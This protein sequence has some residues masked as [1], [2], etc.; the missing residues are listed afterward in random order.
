MKPLYTAYTALTSGLFLTGFPIFWLYT[1]LTGRHKR[2]LKERLGFVP[3]I[4]SSGSRHRPRIWIHAASLG[5]VRVASPIISSL[6]RQVPACS[7][8]LSATTDHGRDLAYNTFS[9][10]PVLYAPIDTIFSVK[11]ALYSVQPRVMVFLET[12]I[13]PAWLVEAH[14]MGVKTALIN[15]R[16]SERSIG[17]YLKFRPFFTEILNHFDALSMIM[18]EDARRIQDMGADP[19]KIEINGNA[20]Y[21]LLAGQ[22]NPLMEGE[23]RRV[24]NLVP[25][26]NVFVAGSTR[27]GEEAVILDVFEKIRGPF[28]DTV[29]IIAPRHI[30]RTPAIESILRARGLRCQRRSDLGENGQQREAPVVVMNSF[31]ELFSLYSVGTINFCGASLVPLGGQNPLEAAV[32]GKPVF[33]GPSMGDFRDAKCLLEDL[34]AGIEISDSES[35]AEKA[36]WFL[37]HP[38]ALKSFGRRAR[39][40]VMK[41]RGAAEKHAGVIA[42]LSQ[43][44][45]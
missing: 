34:N 9:D 44:A 39:E 11:R 35:F 27:D 28:P 41:H 17:R 12:E 1:H 2:G 6:R 20:K 5:E 16:I 8:I 31:G 36:I 21:D 18:G 22:A 29:L 23:M 4:I 3:H 19:L 37:K 10:I 24:L 32:W 40:A 45:A 38:E 13:W 42:R 33:Y 25:S 30:D 15:G 7:V 43:K 14:R 26:Q